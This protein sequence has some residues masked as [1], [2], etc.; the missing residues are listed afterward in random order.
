MSDF[1]LLITDWYR[2]N[3]RNLPWRETKDPYLI[4]ISE[5]ILQQTRVDQGKNYYEKFKR[6]YPT[7]H[8]LAM[9]S[10]QEVLRDWQGLGYY[11]RARNLHASAKEISTNMKG[12]FP[13]RY[14][15]II[16]LKGVGSYTAAAIS[17]IA[18]DEKQAVVDGNVYRV[19]SR[20]F[21]IETPIDGTAGKKQFQKLADELI[22]EHNP[23]EHNQAVME[24]GA[25]ICKPK[26]PECN[27]CPL[28]SKCLALSNKTI[29][30]RPIKI[31]KVKTR[32]RY[33]QFLIFNDGESTVIEKR[34]DKDIWRNMYQFPLIE[35]KEIDANKFGVKAKESAPVKHIL[36]HQKIY[37]TFHHFDQMPQKL[38]DN[39]MVVKWSE[40]QEYPIPRIIDKYLESQFK[41]D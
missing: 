21:D 2:L 14:D 41:N 5:I 8:D 12:S 34:D 33:F 36:S 26:A 18:F 6:H 1:S 11:S 30:Q 9:A 35:K 16:K 39:W 13:V 31:K 20:V 10:E 40:L 29:D 32:E 27:T 7:V 23:G 19:L 38:Q 25:L 17:S 37:G 15:D 3:Y 4:W 24:L 28:N 22:L